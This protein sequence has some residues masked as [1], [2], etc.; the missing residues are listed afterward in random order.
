MK[1]V[2]LRTESKAD[3]NKTYEDLCREI[4]PRNGIERMFVGEVAYH[5]LE[6]VRYG[7]IK[8]A[9][10][11]NALQNALEHIL[12]QI[13]LPPST[14]L[15]LDIWMAPKKLAYD[16]LVDPEA[17]RRVR[18][19]LKEA[20]CDESAI[21]AQAFNMVADQ[22]ENAARMMERAREGRDKALR[23]IVKYRKSFADQLR[24][25]SDRLIAEVE[26]ASRLAN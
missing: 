10:L 20:G 9:I 26:A 1:N 12:R 13:L 18:A 8:T 24:R 19:V 4:T 6:Y 5:V 14:H 16:W 22:L 7:R 25:S 17:K 21:E 15:S 2:L 23:S 3:F 11:N